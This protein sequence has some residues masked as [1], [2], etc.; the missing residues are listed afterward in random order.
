MKKDSKSVNPVMNKLTKEVR[1]QYLPQ[2]IKDKQIQD[3]PEKYEKKN[4]DKNLKS[5]LEFKGGAD[6]FLFMAKIADKKYDPLQE[7]VVVQNIHNDIQEMKLNEYNKQLLENTTKNSD[8]HINK[9]LI[10]YQM[11][12]RPKYKDGMKAKEFENLENE[13]YLNWRRGISEVELKNEKLVITPYEKNIS[14]WRQLWITIEKCQVL[15]QIVDARNPLFFRSSDLENYIKEVDSKKDYLLLINKADLLS[16]ELRI[17]WAEYFMKKGINFIFFSALIE[18]IKLKDVEHNNKKHQQEKLDN[19]TNNNNNNNQNNNNENND[20]TDDEDENCNK[21]T[22]KEV[23]AKELIEK[24]INSDDA[25]KKVEDENLLLPKSYNN[26]KLSN[27]G[28]PIDNLQ[29]NCNPEEKV[30]SESKNKFLQQY[31]NSLTKDNYRLFNREELIIKL[32]E[33]TKNKEKTHNSKAWLVGFIGYPNVGKSS[34]INVLMQK[35]KVSVA[36]MPGKTKHIQTLFLPDDNELCAMDCPGLVFP[37]FSFSK[38]DLVINGILPIDKIIDYLTP[39]QLV[40]YNI[41][42]CVLEGFYKLKLPDLYS[43]SQFL[44]VMASK[45]G[46]LTGRS[47]PNESKAAKIVLKDYISGNLLFCYT[48]PDYDPIIHGDLTTYLFKSPLIENDKKSF[49]NENYSYDKLKENTELLKQIPADFN[50]NFE[51]CGIDVG[52]KE[53]LK[54]YEDIDNQFFNDLDKSNLDK[55]NQSKVP[56]DMRMQLKFAMKRGDISE[57]DYEN[58]F[59]FQEAKEMLDKIEKESIQN[60]VNKPKSKVNKKQKK[61]FENYN[62]PKI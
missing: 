16:E 46:Y 49:F 55:I 59:T 38:A 6:E 36:L 30:E 32:K 56:K 18:D 9:S 54:N 5:T 11:P 20:D 4:M 27:I 58:I 33:L 10:G 37:S 25:R 19:E 41:H 45:F 21:N 22:S 62:V 61:Y 17:S 47:I 35:K 52:T 42:K 40:I 43:A 53:T 7:Q 13:A 14:V 28:K 15:C 26:D 31:Y 2:K 60:Q 44:Q 51:K 3:N 8:I 39:I 57:E 34:V 48:R 23:Q 12:K 29:L 50:D 1:S 24:P